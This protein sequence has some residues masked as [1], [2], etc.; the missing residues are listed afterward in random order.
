MSVTTE[1]VPQADELEL[2]IV[3][4]DEK[5][6]RNYVHIPFDK[7]DCPVDPKVRGSVPGI[8]RRV[9]KLWPDKYAD[10]TWPPLRT[11]EGLID[12]LEKMPDS[13]V[14]KIAEHV[15]VD[16]EGSLEDIA[17]AALASTQD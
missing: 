3:K 15:G 13:K 2:P 8:K 6:P 10:V 12:T 4:A 5:K 7:M 14:E 1:A 17:K 9:K 11:I 16:N